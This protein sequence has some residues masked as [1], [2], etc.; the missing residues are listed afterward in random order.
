MIKLSKR[1]LASR[2]FGPQTIFAS[3]EVAD[4]LMANP[5]SVVLWTRTKGLPCHRTPGGHRRF[6]A[7]DVV[8][9]ARAFRIP[10]PPELEDL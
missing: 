10:L 2:P 4:I 7:C 3:S 8:R 5:S 9:F 6:M 1:T